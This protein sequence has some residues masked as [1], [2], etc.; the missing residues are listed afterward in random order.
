MAFWSLSAHFLLKLNPE[1]ESTRKTEWGDVFWE[2]LAIGEV[3]GDRHSRQLEGSFSS[4]VE[5]RRKQKQKEGNGGK[6]EEERKKERKKKKRIGLMFISLMGQE[7][8]FWLGF[9]MGF[10]LFLLDFGLG[11]EVRIYA[12]FD[13]TWLIK[14]WAGLLA[15]LELSAGL[16]NF[17]PSNNKKKGPMPFAWQKLKFSL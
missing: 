10:G 5:K 15:S 3:A 14:K 7:L 8:Y 6:K 17:G 1:I 16:R 11:S 2:I 9:G 4:S 12:F 13:W